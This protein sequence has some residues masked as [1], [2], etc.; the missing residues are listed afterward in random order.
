MIYTNFFYKKYTENLIL[1]IFLF[2]IFSLYLQDKCK[3]GTFIKI[4]Y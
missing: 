3:K 4:L 1:S 2:G